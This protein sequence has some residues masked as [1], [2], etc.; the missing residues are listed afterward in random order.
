MPS[1]AHDPRYRTLDPAVCARARAHAGLA[2]RAAIAVAAGFTLTLLFAHSG[3]IPS[4]MAANDVG[5]QMPS[6]VALAQDFTAALNTHDVEALVDLFSEEGP[7]ATV[8][9]DRY[10]WTRFEIRLWA[11]H[12]VRANIRIDAYDYRA[13]EH[14]A[15]WDATVYREDWR[16]LGVD[17]LPVINTIW[18]EDGKMTDFTSRL[19]N[20]HD[21]ERL[22]HLWRPGSV[23]DYPTS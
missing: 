2:A 15:A 21:A 6:S 1:I 14:G 10:A 17:A 22:Q 4:V 23:P 13:T 12:Q 7:G 19:A 5:A 16:E 20:P 3:A 11:Q 8:H 18:V 9:A